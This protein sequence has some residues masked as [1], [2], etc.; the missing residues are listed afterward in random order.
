MTTQ[1][2]IS[3]YAHKVM[4]YLGALLCKKVKMFELFG[5]EFFLNSSVIAIPIILA[6][7]GGFSWGVV[8]YVLGIAASILLHE[9]GHALGGYIVGNPA[10]EISLIA[11]GGYTIF[12]RNPGVTAKDAFMSFAGPMTNGLVCSLIIWIE[13]ALWGG[14]FGE[15]VHVLLSQVFGKDLSTDELPLSFVM[16]NA[17]AIVNAYM[18]LFNLLP[19]FPLDGG[20]IFR[21]F[22]GCFMSSQKAAFTTML[23]ARLLACLIVGRSIM[24]DLIGEFSPFNLGIMVLIAVWIWWGSKT[25][26]WRT[27]LYCAAEA[28]SSAAI[29]EI[30]RLFDED[31]EPVIHWRRW[32]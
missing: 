13:I 2:G 1:L 14:T 25:E 4:D 10:K 17:I 6:F 15:W 19:A 23:V 28:G 32:Q 31:V 22:S 21:W 30:R 20:R 11:C 5:I 12:S 9:M 24:M 26:L 29:A 27:K 16:M 8:I 3:S 18:L 7:S